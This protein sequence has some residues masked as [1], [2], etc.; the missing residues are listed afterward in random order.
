MR[1]LVWTDDGIGLAEVPEVAP[2][3]GEVAVAVQVVGICGSDVSSY[4]RELTPAVGN[5][6]GHE[7]SGTV[8]EVGEGVDEGLLGRRVTVSA[9]LSCGECWACRSGADNQ[10]SQVRLVGVHALG[11]FADRIVVPAVNLA[12]VPD[13]MPFERAAAAEPFAQAAHDVRMAQEVADVRTAL[14]IGAG[15]V[16]LLLVNA[17]RLSGIAEIHVVD[18]SADRHPLATRAGASRVVASAAELDPAALERDG[19]DAVF[20]VVGI[21]ETRRQAIE[22]ARRGGVVLMVG[23]HADETDIP[24][25][26]MIRKELTLRGANA[27]SRAAF[28]AAV[29]WL[30]HEEVVLG[31]QPAFVPLDEGP[32]AFADLSAGRSRASKTYLVVAR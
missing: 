16:G 19:Y 24:W 29:D 1:A 26:A 11:G 18:P 7:L 17:A 6:P 13:T 31:D 15:S 12:V 2:G 5:V 20:D 23:L 14:V 4:R 10:C 21:A 30:E 27:F 25:R 22:L 9:V 3:P 8:A 28:D 32:A